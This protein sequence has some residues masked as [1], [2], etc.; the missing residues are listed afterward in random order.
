M[1]A[2]LQFGGTTKATVVI[3]LPNGDKMTY[4]FPYVKRLT[5]EQG[6]REIAS[7][8]GWRDHVSTG[9][10]T[11]TLFGQ[12]TGVFTPNP[13]TPT[14]RAAIRIADNLW[15]ASSLPGESAPVGW[16]DTVEQEIKAING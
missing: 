11:I 5:Q 9:E 1:S 3:E 13:I 12:A 6:L 7:R 14:R 10:I 4:D 16:A 8:S 2:S 15:K